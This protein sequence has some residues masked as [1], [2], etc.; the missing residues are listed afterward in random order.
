MAQS[1]LTDSP[2]SDY[3][4]AS[5]EAVVDISKYQS[6]EDKVSS[7]SSAFEQVMSQMN[8]ADRHDFDIQYDKY[9]QEASE[10]GELLSVLICEIDFFKDYNDNYGHQGSAFMLLVIGLAL[11]NTCEKFGCYLARYRGDE[12]AILIKGGDV[13]A[14]KEI[15][16]ALRIAVEESRTEHK[17]SEV[18]D[19]V[20]LSIGL[21]SLYPSSMKV[22]MQK[23]ANALYTAK[24]SGRNQVSCSVDLK[25][26]DAGMGS[27]P[28]E[29]ETINEPEPSDFDRLMSEMQIYDR[30]DFNSYFVNAWQ[31]SSRD[32][33]LLSMVICELD[34]FEEYASHYGQQTSED[35]LLIA[36]CT[37]KSKCEEFGCFIA[38][39]EGAKFVALVKGGNATKGLKVA[40][41]LRACIQ[42][43]A[44]EHA[45]SPVK[46]SLTMS[47]GLSNIFP[48]DENSM[49]TLMTKVDNA[50]SD[51]KSSGFDQISVS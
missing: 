20:T 36:A 6:A 32:Q 15:A 40:E 3:E 7:Q 21:S 26:E 47:L 18:S 37:L 29:L 12:F 16:E 45:L 10:N 31:E 50:L 13:E 2:N 11:K 43:L 42:E 48:S 23:S 51:A 33:E 25:N 34:F 1:N 38:R 22:L 28:L 46:N 39:L 44:M 49:K 35:V 14:S 19:V 27:D 24:K 9:W 30:R 5:S 8:I 41:S 17:Y 4:S